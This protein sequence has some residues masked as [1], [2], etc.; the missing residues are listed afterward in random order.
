MADVTQSDWIALGALG[1]AGLAV[2]VALW[3]NRKADTANTIAQ[4]SL[5]AQVQVL[6]PPWGEAV[7]G[8][9]G[10]GLS[11]CNQSGRHMFVEGIWPEPKNG[12]RRIVAP[13]TLPYRVENGD[14]LRVLSG[15]GLTAAEAGVAVISWRFEGETEL[16]RTERRL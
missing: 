5:D 15:V 8:V 12:A 14:W 10:S 11:F 3:A 6:P 9:N 13:A 4:K 16:H 7:K 2:F 1:I